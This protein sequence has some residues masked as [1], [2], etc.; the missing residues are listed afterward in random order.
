M[1]EQSSPLAEEIHRRMLAAGLNPKSLSL[2][3]GL[4]ETFVRDILKGRTRY[5]RTDTLAKLAAALGC[6]PADLL[7]ADL[8]RPARGGPRSIALEVAIASAFSESRPESFDLVGDAVI[9]P[10]PRE[11][12]DTTQYFAA[13]VVDDS[14]DVVYPP[15]TILLVH[16][17]ASVGS[18]KIGDLVIAMLWR[19]RRNRRGARRDGRLLTDRRGRAVHE[20]P[21]PR[22]PGLRAG[23]ARSRQ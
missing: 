20:E 3:A 5:P 6:S 17:L 11:L 14:L 10:A 19:Q 8:G 2:R 22:D 7:P 13:R 4:N 15:G 9:V 23:A 1:A 21:Q 16:R 12:G 18:L